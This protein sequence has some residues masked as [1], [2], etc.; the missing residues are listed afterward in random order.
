MLGHLEQAAKSDP[1]QAGRLV[2]GREIHV[3]VRGFSLL[4][5]SAAIIGFVFAFAVIC[6]PLILYLDVLSG[7]ETEEAALVPT[8][9]AAI[10][11]FALNLHRDYKRR[12]T[13]AEQI[14]RTIAFSEKSA[15]D[16]LKEAQKIAD[17]Q[18]GL[19]T[20]LEN[21]SPD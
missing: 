3:A 20:N 17:V 19:P 15:A 9:M 7:I 5:K 13:Y 11:A 6:W 4:T 12:Q 14:L 1:E 10:S 16:L 8:T 18:V 2:L 21:K